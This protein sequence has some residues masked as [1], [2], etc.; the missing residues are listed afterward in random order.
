MHP[1]L[2][3]NETAYP[4]PTSLPKNVVVT[5]AGG[6]IGLSLCQSLKRQGHTVVG[7]DLPSCD[8]VKQ[9]TKLRDVI[10]A[11][12][13]AVVYHLAADK[14][15]PKGEDHPFETSRVNI[16]GTE[17]VVHACLD[18]DA[19]VILA[20]TCKAAEPETCYGASKLIAERIVLNAGGTVGRLY[21]VVESHGNVFSVWADQ[22]AKGKALTYVYEA[23]RFFISRGEAVSFLLSIADCKP[24][25]Y[26]PDPGAAHWM[27]DM[28]QRYAREHEKRT[29]IPARRG[30]RLWEPMCAEHESMTKFGNRFLISS[31]HDAAAVKPT[32]VAA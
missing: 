4:K 1:L 27:E 12:S 3:R 11:H 2:A 17:N 16:E 23:K 10:W 24:G 18:V 25:R 22:R 15:A 21:N 19:R 6:S 20:S 13:P 28:C 5:G 29:D 26:A 32:M 14:H 9:P 7:L 30:D 8:I 31:P